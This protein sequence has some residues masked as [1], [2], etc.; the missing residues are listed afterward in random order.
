MKA[1][2]S[3]L[4]KNGIEIIPKNGNLPIAY[5]EISMFETKNPVLGRLAMEA[6]LF[7][8]L[9]HIIDPIADARVIG[10]Y[11]DGMLIRGIEYQQGK[12]VAQEW[13]VRLGW[14]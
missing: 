6:A 4:Y 9:N 13:W 1:A 12:E 14:F 5:G 2:V 11:A 10:M 8:G 7:D 3:V